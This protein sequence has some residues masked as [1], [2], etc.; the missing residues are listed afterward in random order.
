MFACAALFA[1]SND[2]VDQA[3]DPTG[4]KD[5]AYVA[6]SL[7]NATESADAKTRGEAGN[8]EFEYGTTE[9]DV[10]TVEFYFYN[11]DGAYNQH[12]DKVLNW[13]D[14]TTGND[15]VEKY[16]V[17]E[18]A[19]IVLQDLKTKGYPKYVVAVLN[20]P[21]GEYKGLT[22]DEL[23]EQIVKSHL[24]VD[25]AY[26][27]TNSTYNN[28]VAAS[29]YFATTLEDSNFLNEAPGTKQDLTDANVVKIYV[30]RLAA[31]VTLAT[32][33]GVGNSITL[34]KYEV[35]GVQKDIK[36]NL[37]GWGLNATA[38]DSY[39]MKHVPAWD[40]NLGFAW[41]VPA[42]YRSYW[43]E[44]TNYGK[45]TYPETYG[46]TVDAVSSLSNINDATLTYV[47]WNSLTTPLS[48]PCYCMENTNTADML[49]NNNFRATATHVLIQAQIDGGTDLIQFYGQLYTPAE[50]IKT[51][52]GQAL[53]YKVDETDPANT[54][55]TKIEPTDVEIK[56][57]YDGK[58]E[59]KLTAA[60]EA[61]KWSTS[62]E[63]TVTIDAV[64]V[65]A[66]L[67]NIFVANTAEYYKA[68]MMY[69]CIPIEH[70]RGG[71]I[72]YENDGSYSLNEADYGV[73][74]NHWYQITVNSIKNLGSAVFNPDENI[75]PNEIE[76]TYYVGAQINILS[77]KIVK[78][79]VDL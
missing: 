43:G 13:T 33:T 71:Q 10:K 1:C 37:L 18:D 74:R 64:D 61:L 31:K 14:K 7:V 20:G 42:N 25:G 50:F 59:L 60:A 51:A 57:V 55:Y 76:P 78:Q 58:V 16:S 39:T 6:I 34:T 53:Y 24:S 67:A 38:E 40:A 69:Y 17:I 75:V 45:G 35:D 63:S 49:M 2:E 15:N 3:T 62:K 21:V 30:E 77:W 27:M 5:Q 54:V 56:N 32:A 72:K 9:N 11:A 79:G 73:V 26:M 68:G 70:L 23:N 52:L 41:S 47:S 65:N 28:G 22:L 44:S 48:T 29:K 66:G 46:S 12:T 4:D 8:P 36:I 19:A